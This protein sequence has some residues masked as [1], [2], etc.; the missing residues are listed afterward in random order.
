MP[1]SGTSGTRTLNG[2]INEESLDQAVYQ[3]NAAERAALAAAGYTGFPSS[4]E[5][6]LNTPFPQWRCIANVLLVDEPSEKCNGLINRSNTRQ[7]TAGLSAQV[8]FHGT[9]GPRRNQLTGADS[10]RAAWTSPS[11][12]NSGI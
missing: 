8:T 12:L 1:T 5:S 7:R 11:P 6:A 4:G 3:P 2:D 9:D 10:T